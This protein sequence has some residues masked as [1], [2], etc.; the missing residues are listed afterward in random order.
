M[1]IGILAKS[2]NIFSMR[3]VAGILERSHAYPEVDLQVYLAIPERDRLGDIGILGWDG[4]LCCQKYGNFHNDFCQLDIPVVAQSFQHIEL[5]GI[6]EAGIDN[7]GIGRVAAEHLY[8]QGLRSFLCLPSHLLPSAGERWKGFADT[9]ASF[10]LRSECFPSLE[11][12]ENPSWTL[13]EQIKQYAEVFSRSEQPLGVFTTSGNHGLWAIQAAKMAGLQIPQDVAII[14]SSSNNPMASEFSDPPLS[15]IQIFHERQGAIALDWMVRRLRDGDA[16]NRLA[17]ASFD[18][19]VRESSCHAMSRDPLIARSLN[20]ITTNMGENLSNANIAKAVGASQRS[21]ERRFR[22]ILNRGLAES[23][24]LIRIDKTLKLLTQSTLALK[25]ITEQLGW[26]EQSQMS[27]AI[28]EHTGMSPGVYRWQHSPTQAPPGAG[29][30]FL[31]TNLDQQ[32]S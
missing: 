19:F 2:D 18:L 6:Q 15:V 8:S 32:N 10:G 1:R 29:T 30:T 27:R 12:N 14:C 16:P 23:V 4:L 5:A 20:Y 9:L 11:T 21:L 17:Y 24:K 25:E 26:S 31:S 28:K 13:I 3:Y 7:V 22:K